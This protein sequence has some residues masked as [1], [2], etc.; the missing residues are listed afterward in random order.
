VSI[1]LV[2]S[3]IRR[4]LS[5]AEPEVICISGHWGVGKTFAWNQYLK[6]AQAK[7]K[8]ALDRYSYV[9]LFGVNSLDELKYAVFENSLK[10]S[11]I[12]I[13]PSLETLE[14]NLFGMI[15]SLTRKTARKAVGVAQQTPFLKNYLGGLAP[16]WFS[17]VRA[18]V[19]CIDDF[20]RRGTD[21]SVRDVLGLINNL[22]EVKRCKICLILNDEALE[23]HE[24][25]FRKYLEK[26]VDA[27]LKFQPSPQD[28][29]RIALAQDSKVTRLLAS[30]SVK[31]GIS[32][33]RVIK[34]IERSIRQAEP[35]VAGFDEQVLTQAIHSLT[36]IGWILFE[37][38][39]APSLD[40]LKRR[41]VIDFLKV[42]EKVPVPEN[43]ASWNALLGVYGFGSM[44]EFDLALLDGIRNGYFDPSSVI[45]SGSELDKKIKAG[46]LDAAF[47]AAWRMYHDSFDDDEDKVLDAMHEA[48]FKGV[49]YI[50]PMNMSA[51]VALFKELGRETQ[52]GE[53]LRYYI[54]ARGAEQ[55]LFNLRSYPFLDRVSDPDVVQAFKEK[56]A[57]FKQEVS[58]K[59]I[60]LRIADTH[61]WN[62]EDIT[63]L[64]ELPVDEYYKLFKTDTGDR[65]KIIGACLMF[66][67][68][69]NATADY[70]EL[71]KRAKEALKR[72]GQES[73]INARR[74]KAYGVEIDQATSHKDKA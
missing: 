48:F 14:S 8:I 74:V 37:P 46:N 54:E 16:V 28:C 23:E 30:H 31:L 22:K 40:Y 62:S 66:D 42:D 35:L 43:E 21:L 73:R 61:S 59:E 44:D 29:A 34:K 71:V 65:R 57:T 64:S 13:A 55:Q 50:N 63:T 56:H 17:S 2:V 24:A 67:T 9:S 72:I 68:M 38:T 49:Q 6:D 5:T 19:V 33:I 15:D 36:L 32:N 3:E 20:E 60:L 58:P 11:E 52:A 53:M 45:K 47:N 39:K 70:Q 41:G 51:T 27:T 1:D 4:F 12:G 7:N 69:M 25:E 26:V 18:N 10:T